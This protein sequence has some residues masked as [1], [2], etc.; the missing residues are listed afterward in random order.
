MQHILDMLSGFQEASCDLSTA[1]AYISTGQLQNVAEDG[2]QT[3][4]FFGSLFE[5]FRHQQVWGPVLLA[6]GVLSNKVRGNVDLAKT[7]ALNTS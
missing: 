5:K 2:R 1:F 4:V 6:D 7:G 3:I